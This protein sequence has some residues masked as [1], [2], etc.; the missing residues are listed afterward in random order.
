MIFAKITSNVQRRKEN[1]KCKTP[2]LRFYIKNNRN[3]HSVVVWEEKSNYFSIGYLKGKVCIAYRSR[4]KI[5]FV[6]G[7]TGE[8][9]LSS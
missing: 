3:D 7:G 1:S 6:I 5:V 8:G 9:N 4:Y 2:Y